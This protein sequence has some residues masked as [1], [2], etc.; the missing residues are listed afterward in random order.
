MVKYCWV[1]CVLALLIIS[2]KSDVTKNMQDLDLM[3]KGVPIKIKAPLDAEVVVEDLGVLKDIT[4]T[5]GDHY[6]LQI[7][8][9]NAVSFDRADLVNDHKRQVQEDN[10]FSKFILEEEN[11]FIYE[12]QI[13]SN[14]V[15]Y[16]FRYI[17]IQGDQEYIFQTGLFGRFDKSDVEAMYESVK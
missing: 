7:L 16:D 11:G 4:V 5:K 12:K 1:C 17:K 3:F 13:D 10:F 6:N 2:C 8:S 14:T 15:N 9:S